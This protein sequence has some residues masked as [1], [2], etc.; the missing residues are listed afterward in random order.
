MVIEVEVDFEILEY[1]KRIIKAS[2][3]KDVKL[4]HVSNIFKI[5]GFT[6]NVIRY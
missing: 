4:P 6:K 2:S 1:Q 3:K 5:N